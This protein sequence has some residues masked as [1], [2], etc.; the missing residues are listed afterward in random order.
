[1]LFLLSAAWGLA[2]SNALTPEL[3]A[4]LQ[5]VRELLVRALEFDEDY[6]RGSLHNALITIEAFATGA[7]R[8]SRR[9]RRAVR[10][11][12]CGRRPCS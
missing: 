5:A 9:T 8:S 11:A 2:I 6:E 7:G 12:G 10:C 4:D 3:V 1:M